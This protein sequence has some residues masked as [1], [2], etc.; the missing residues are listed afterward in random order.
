MINDGRIFVYVWTI[1]LTET[2]RKSVENCVWLPWLISVVPFE[3]LRSPY[4]FSVCLT[5]WLSQEWLITSGGIF[6]FFFCFPEPTYITMAPP[7]CSSLDNCTLVDKSCPYGFRLDSIGC[8]T[9]SCKTRKWA[10]TSLER[11]FI[12]LTPYRRCQAVFS[13]FLSRHWL[14]LAEMFMRINTEGQM[15]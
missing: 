9:C 12:F 10:V 15:D 13:S 1:L 11:C 14:A 4:S 7:A 6:Y 5:L 3:P 2:K 8:R